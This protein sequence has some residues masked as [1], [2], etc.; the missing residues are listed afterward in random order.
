MKTAIVCLSMALAAGAQTLDT[1]YQ[2]G[3]WFQFRDA[4]ARE[5]KPSAFHRAMLALAFH[6]WDLAQKESRSLLRPDADPAQAVETALGLEQVYTMSGRF[7]D[8]RE[9]LARLDRLL[10][11]F[12]S[13]GA[14]E[15]AALHQFE[16]LRAE[17]DALAGYPDQ[18]VVARGRSRLLYAE[19]DNELLIPLRVNR[20]PA[21][22]VIDTGSEMNYL[23]ASEARRLGLKVRPTSIPLA[24]WGPAGQAA[25]GVAVADD[26]VI[27]NFHLRN[28]VFGVTPDDE[29]GSGAAGIVG[30]PVL[31]ALETLRWNSDGAIEFGFPPPP[32][33]AANLC[34]VGGLLFTQASTAG[35]NVLLG[36][37]T[38]SFDTEL[39]PRFG[40]DFPALLKTASA[41][42]PRDIGNGFTDPAAATLAEL[43]IRVGGLE[44]MLRP[45]VLLSSEPVE[46]GEWLHGWLGVDLLSQ[47]RST[48]LDLRGM[49]LTLEGAG[50]VPQRTAA[51]VC[52]LPAGFSCAPGFA[53]TV[54]NDPGQPCFIDRLPVETWP[55]NPLTA[56]VPQNG[57]RCVLSAGVRCDDGL[58]C[59][60]VFESNQSCHIAREAAPRPLSTS[61]TLPPAVLPNPSPQ[62]D[63]TEMVRRSLKY[64]SL[65]LTPAKD[66]V[67][68]EDRVQRTLDS[69]GNVKDT[70]SETHEVMNLYDQ[71]YSRLIR[72][73]GKPLEPAKAR[74]EQVRFDKAVARRA[75]E[76][77]AA[78]SKREEAQRKDAA[79]SLACDDEFM[80]TFTFRQVG[81]E[82]V[83]GRP[84]WVVELEPL[85]N[86]QPRCP[87]MKV[88]AQFHFRLWIDRED[89][90][91]AR[92]EGDNIAP[93]TWARLLL[94]MP[95]GAVH[96]IFEQTRHEDGAWLES[97]MEAKMSAKVLLLAT[98]RMD[99]TWTYSNYR[100]FQADSRLVPLVEEQK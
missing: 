34:F 50:A 37:D 61:A 90:R 25:T 99:V 55:G 10:H 12:E 46:G 94:R 15:P 35:R 14:I 54:K 67:Y 96:L 57:N 64:E 27:G 66:Y 43:A 74:A 91:W 19:T 36:L 59:S 48:T 58:A 77:P 51:A 49:R 83:N 56:D 84:A 69:S 45:A 82:S 78:R 5:I 38:G 20:T 63:A 93:V 28:V 30:M 2:S 98:V 100:K 16:S 65:D 13:T 87:G 41:R 17:L 32:G 89:Y 47:A 6:D 86:T 42:A 33:A 1:L 26:L 7:Q 44:T 80:R 70:S 68:I 8:A 3:E 79:E 88:L 18:T 72:K 11:D 97:R 76:T 4:M 81:S 31:L 52:A 21:N 22:Y 85:K 92:L 29:D 53:C 62:P 40:R 23:S 60:A 71:A 95:T 75:H 24:T 73:N 9:L 39:F